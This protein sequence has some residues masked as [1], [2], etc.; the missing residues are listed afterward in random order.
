MRIQ[1]VVDCGDEVVR[2]FSFLL[3][4][5]LGDMIGDTITCFG[6]HSNLVRLNPPLAPH[7]ASLKTLKKARNNRSSRSGNQCH[8]PYQ[9]RHPPKYVG[10]ARVIVPFVAF[11]VET[12]PYGMKS[13]TPPLS[14]VNCFDRQMHHDVLTPTNTIIALNIY[15]PMG[16][17]RIRPVHDGGKTH[18]SLG[19]CQLIQRYLMEKTGKNRTRKQISSRIQRLRR[20]HQD[21]PSSTSILESEVQG[22]LH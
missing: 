18:A 7:W 22:V 19:R 11:Q 6:R 1:L 3:L 4:S 5:I 13:C 2:D 16:R 17:Q 20:T 12:K 15:P 14:K 8:I 10:K 21:D 9:R